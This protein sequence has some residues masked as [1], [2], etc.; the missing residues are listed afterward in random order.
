MP[1]GFPG[2]SNQTNNIIGIAKIDIISSDIA[3]PRTSNYKRISYESEEELEWIGIEYQF[4]APPTNVIL[5]NTEPK[6]HDVEESGKSSGND[7][8]YDD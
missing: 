1:V 5:A 8:L 3:N 4:L 2:S 7:H 6:N